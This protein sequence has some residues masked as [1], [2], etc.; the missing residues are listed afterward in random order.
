MCTWVVATLCL[1][2]LATRSHLARCVGGFDSNSMLPRIG[3]LPRNLQH[4][5]TSIK[6]GKG[7]ARIFQHGASI[8]PKNGRHWGP[9]QPKPT[10]MHEAWTQEAFTSALLAG[11]GAIGLNRTRW[12]MHPMCSSVYSILLRTCICICVSICMS[13]SSCMCICRSVCLDLFRGLQSKSCMLPETFRHVV[14]ISVALLHDYSGSALQ[15]ALAWF[16]GAQSQHR[17]YACRRSCNRISQLRQ[18]RSILEMHG[19]AAL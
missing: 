19:F 6:A 15:L 18:A 5:A 8:G 4:W 7:S 3:K 12:R 11:E 9:N 13:M 14:L 10:Q 16:G 2:F 1:C 17:W